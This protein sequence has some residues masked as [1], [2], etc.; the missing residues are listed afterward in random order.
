ME[1]T[2]GI[3]SKVISWAKT[4]YILYR[5]VKERQKS[6]VIGSMITILFNGLSVLVSGITSIFVARALGP[7]ELGYLILFMT[8]TNT[9]ALFADVMGIYYSN[10]YLIASNNYGFQLPTV[11]GTVL[12]YGLIVGLVTG[13]MFG[14]ISLFRLLIFR[15][16]DA[17]MWGILIGLNVLGLVLLNQIRGLFLGHSNFLMLG[18]LGLS[19]VALYSILALSLTYILF[20]RTGAEVAMMYLVATWACVAGALV[21]LSHQ[22]IAHPSFRYI[23]ACAQVGWRATLINWLSFLHTRIDQYLINIF[24]GPHALGLY[25]VAVSL[26]ELLTRIPSMLGLVLFPLV[27]SNHDRLGA[28]RDT[29]R[30]TGIVM[31]TVGIFTLILA[32]LASNIVAVLYGGEFSGSAAALRLLLPAIVFLSGLVIINN[33][34]AGLG[35]PPILIASMIVGIGGNILLNLWLLPRI[36]II[37]ASIASSITYGIQFLIELGYLIW[38]LKGMK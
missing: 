27:A 29:L 24:L 22:G 30:R 16:F 18:V 17:P 5:S 1:M 20:R 23:K 34:L 21:L 32:P 33:H 11:R 14:F 25:G 10:A 38:L 8:G 2:T 28:V 37:G 19:Q 35:Y 9:I 31:A 13:S 7:Q 26:G 4:S 12:G 3:S 6:F 36:D 15:G